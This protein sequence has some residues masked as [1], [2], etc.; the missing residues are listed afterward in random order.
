MER[1]LEFFHQRSQILVTGDHRQHARI[2]LVEAM[3]NQDVGDAVVLSG[4]QDDNPLW[5]EPGQTHSGPLGQ[6]FA[7]LGQHFGRFKGSFEFGA[8][9]KCLRQ[10]IYEFLITGHINTAAEKDSSDS[11]DQARTI[12]ALDQKDAAPGF[13]R[14]RCG[15]GQ[16]HCAK[17]SLFGRIGRK[18]CHGLIAA[19][20]CH[21]AR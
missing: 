6:P 3:P 16:R 10:S 19:A 12:L 18:A 13:A 8:H 2:K 7:D 4:C 11:V 5:S 20:Q 9:I 1:D 14:L 15:P 17:R 21:T